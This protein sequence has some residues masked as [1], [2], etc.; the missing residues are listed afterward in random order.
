[1][2]YTNYTTITDL[3]ADLAETMGLDSYDVVVSIRCHRSLFGR[4]EDIDADEQEAIARAVWADVT[5]GAEYPWT[6]VD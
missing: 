3:A 5:A 6:R 1:M 4:F 2:K